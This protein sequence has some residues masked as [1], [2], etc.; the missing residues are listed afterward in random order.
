MEKKIIAA[1]NIRDK[2]QRVRYQDFRPEKRDVQ[3]RHLIVFQERKYLPIAQKDR[4]CVAVLRKRPTF[5]AFLRKQEL[6]HIQ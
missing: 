6:K 5:A 4:F 1:Y 3:G 2:A